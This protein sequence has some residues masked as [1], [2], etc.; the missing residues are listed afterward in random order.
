VIEKQTRGQMAALQKQSEAQARKL[1]TD[2]KEAAEALQAALEAIDPAPIHIPI[3]WD[4]PDLPGGRVSMPSTGPAAGT[5]GD[6]ATSGGGTA[7][8]EVDGRVLA[9]VVVPQIPGV[10]KRFGLR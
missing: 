8:L 5:G 4:V 10:V 9:E 6:A 2:A 7:V 1:E 3:V